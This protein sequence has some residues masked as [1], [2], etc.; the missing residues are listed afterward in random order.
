MTPSYYK[1]L[2]EVEGSFDVVVPR[3]SCGHI[4]PLCGRFSRS[5]L[6]AIEDALSQGER[7]VFRLLERKDRDVKEVEVATW[8]IADSAFFNVNTLEDYRQ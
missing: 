8:G 7:K 3:D 5:C 1:S 2:R 4:H 6:A